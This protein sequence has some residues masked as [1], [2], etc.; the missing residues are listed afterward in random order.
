[1]IFHTEERTHTVG[2][3][4]QSAVENVWT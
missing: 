1:M 4:E 3:C 2:V